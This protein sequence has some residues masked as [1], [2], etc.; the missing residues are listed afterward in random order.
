VNGND[1]PARTAIERRAYESFQQRGSGH[2]HDW[3]DWFEA[4]REVTGAFYAD[5][6]LRFGPEGLIDAAQW[7]LD[8]LEQVGVPRPPGN[9]LQNART[10]IRRVNDRQLL[11]TA[12]DDDL[13][14]RV[15]EAQKTISEQYVI[16]RA[17]AGR[18]NGLRL[19][20][21]D[22]VEMMLSGAETADADANPLARNTQ[23]E[24]YVAAMLA[25]G[26]ADVRVAEPDLI[27]RFLGHDVGIAAKRVRS[28]SRV[29][30]IV[31][32]AVAQVTRSARPGFVALN[33]DVLV[34]NTG[35]PA[36]A[37]R[38]DERL[39]A[40]AAM[41]AQL[42]SEPNILGSMVFGYDTQWIF[43]GER[44][45]VHVGTFLRIRLT[46]AGRRIAPEA[47]DAAAAILTNIKQRLPRL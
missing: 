37:I 1:D 34:R 45:Q 31:D 32:E 14:K 46:S 36:D 29:P 9:R 17:T 8:R 26:G 21:S 30:R 13:L 5:T 15:T 19:E 10:L 22:K 7:T 12:N 3:Q 38:L 20:I 25:M 43:G 41:D 11:L 4:E 27:M 35:A 39:S 47:R 33:V 6:V 2:G 28:I 24:L 40:L 44:P 18:G 23:F 42:R 16:V